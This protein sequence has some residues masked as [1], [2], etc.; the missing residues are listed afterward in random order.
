MKSGFRK[1]LPRFLFGLFDRQKP[2]EPMAQPPQ[3]RTGKAKGGGKRRG[4]IQ[5]S[6]HRSARSTKLGAAIM[7]YFEKGKPKYGRP[8]LEGMRELM[9]PNWHS[10]N[11][12]VGGDRRRK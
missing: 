3:K 2:Q 4:F 10:Q 11:R 1:F 5:G 8:N 12:R 9:E 7:L 6:P